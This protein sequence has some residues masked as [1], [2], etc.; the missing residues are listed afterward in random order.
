M[1]TTVKEIRLQEEPCRSSE[2]GKPYGVRS[3]ENLCSSEKCLGLLNVF[4]MLCIK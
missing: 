4:I 3:L 1:L 2:K